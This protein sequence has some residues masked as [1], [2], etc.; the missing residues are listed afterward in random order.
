MSKRLA[1]IV[2]VV[3]GLILPHIAV[4]Q[5]A[6]GITDEDRA[7]FARHRAALLERLGEELAVLFGAAVREDHLRFRQDN[8]FYYF[9]GVETAFATL[10]L[11]GRTGSEILF[12]PRTSATGERW[13]G[14]EIGPGPEAVAEYGIADVREI[15]EMPAAL[16]QL[17]SAGG[18]IGTLLLREE[19][20]SGGRDAAWRDWGAGYYPPWDMHETRTERIAAWLQETFPGV[21]VFDISEHADALRRIKSSW[22]IDL[23]KE[24][25]R[26]AGEGHLAAMRITRPGMREW[27]LEAAAQGSFISEGAFYPSYSAIVA[28]G[29]NTAIIHYSRS[30]DIVAAKDLVMM[31]FGP[32]YRYYSA[33]IT[34]TWPAS[35]RFK[36][37]HR[38]YYLDLL[39]IHEA[40]IE[41]VRPGITLDDIKERFRELLIEKGYYERCY[42]FTPCHYI[43]MS[44]H[45]VGSRDAPLEPGVVL[46]IEPGLYFNNM[47]LGIRVEDVVLVTPDGRR[48][49]S[50]M[51]PIRPEDIEA[52]MAGAD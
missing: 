28:S 13:H 18:R 25:C 17:V 46:C 34:R 19:P 49:L 29:R 48:V 14:K 39:D 44:V 10:I 5:I 22:E 9:T 16:A 38:R 12:L 11:D 40:M 50:K 2:C 42:F 31:D 35:G 51:I 23:I 47:K 27:E 6:T 15:V 24:A 36:K 1:F 7:E 26:I 33:D 43:G 32:D 3:I 52:I 45:D 8:T 20:V 30:S 41:F 37:K 21:T 4:A